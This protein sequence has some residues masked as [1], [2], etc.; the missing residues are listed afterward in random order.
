MSQINDEKW[1]FLNLRSIKEHSID[2]EWR[3]LDLIIFF[4]HCQALLGNLF[5][6]LKAVLQK[7]T[8]KLDSL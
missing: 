6:H 5:L 1:F 3:D 7:G 2:Y 8:F 4:Y